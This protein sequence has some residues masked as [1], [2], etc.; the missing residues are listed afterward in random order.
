MNKPAKKEKRPVSPKRPSDASGIPHS[1]GHH[2]VVNHLVENYSGP[3]PHPAILERFNAIIPNGAER[4][5]A[6]VEEEQRHRQSLEKDMV[7]QDGNEAVSG[8]KAERRGQFLA[9]VIC[10]S[11]IFVAREV[12]LSGHPGYA[13]LL[14]GGTLAGIITAFVSGNFKGSAPKQAEPRQDKE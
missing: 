11:L 10:L 13:T 7:L 6:M 4:I 2:V 14:A 12:A 8:R 1:N 9:A 3:I 5:M